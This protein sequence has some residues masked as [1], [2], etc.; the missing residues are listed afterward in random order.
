MYGKTAGERFQGGGAGSPAPAV[1]GLHYNQ[2]GGVGSG[3]PGAA[4]Q[5]AITSSP[6]VDVFPAL[7]SS[8]AAGVSGVTIHG[9]AYPRGTYNNQDI[10]E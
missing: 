9:Q 7:S 1:D 8:A 6:V 5:S 3:I 4:G 10:R 2:T